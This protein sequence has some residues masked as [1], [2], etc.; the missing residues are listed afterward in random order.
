MRVSNPWKSIVF[1]INPNVG[2]TVFTSSFMILFTIVVFPALSRPLTSQLASNLQ[3]AKLTASKLAFLYPL[4][5]PCGEPKACFRSGFCCRMVYR[6]PKD[7]WRGR[8]TSLNTYHS[9]KCYYV[10]LF[11]ALCPVQ[12]DIKALPNLVCKSWEVET[13]QLWLTCGVYSRP[14]IADPEFLL[15]SA[16][17]PVA[18][19]RHRTTCS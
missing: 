16:I 13:S 5:S 2:L 18:L 10:T 3:I 17:S 4:A 14:W 6:A 8:Y 12:C 1:I 19:I 9:S 11:S 15:T 7:F